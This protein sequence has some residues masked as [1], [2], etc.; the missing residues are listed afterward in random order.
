M[1]LKAA[2]D[3]FLLALEADGRRKAT[4][5]WYRS[6]LTGFVV[7]ADP[8][9]ARLLTAITPH[10]MR[11][12]IKALRDR[13]AKYVDAPQRPQL[14]GGLANESIRGHITA[15][16][17]FWNW[18]GR[19]YDISSPMKNIRRP[20]REKPTPRA[21]EAAN[22]ISLFNATGD[23]DAGIRDRAVLTFLADTGSRAG[24]IVTARTDWYFPDQ[25]IAQVI[26][27]GGKARKV[28]FT[29]Y[30]VAS[31][32]QWLQVRD[33][34]TKALFVNLRTGK[35]LTYSGIAQ[36]IKRLKLR[37][38]VT[39]RVN[40]HSFRHRFA[41]EYLKNG[42]DVAVLAKFLGNSIQVVFDYYSVFDDHELV[43]LREQHD[44]L[45]DLIHYSNGKG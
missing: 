8:L 4:V 11:E 28:Y 44:P 35:G 18:C 37:A 10:E 26:G 29:K 39:G 17:A 34:N 25:K 6:T 40:L 3:E 33:S 27:K 22:F 19:E 23:D 21:I 9:D 13:E 38:G 2:L 1:K 20:K 45:H 5:K 42:G 12:Y 36:I 43:E 31:M 30:T 32:A 41:L 16:H 15:L 14:D 7:T 24:D